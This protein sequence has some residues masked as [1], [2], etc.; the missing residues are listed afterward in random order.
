MTGRDGLLRRL[1]A[2]NPLPSGTL[3][4]G[5]GLLV[6][7]ITSYA[8]LAICSHALGPQRYAPISV[9]WALVYFASP[10]FF[11]PLEQE[12]G[13]ALSAR[14]V[15]GAGG[16]PVVR[17]AATAGFVLALVL[18]V[19]AAAAQQPLVD[20]LF[21]G[22]RVLVAGFA[23]AVLAYAAYY[24]VRGVLAGTGHFG[25]YGLLL[26]A[27]GLVRVLASAA[28][29]AAGVRVAGVYGLTIA[30]GAVAGWVAAGRAARDGMQ[31]GPHA[32]WSEITTNIGF[33]LAG[34]AAMQLLTNIGPLAVKVLS[35]SADQAA[36]GVFFNG[37][38]IARIPLFLFQAVQAS[39]LPALSAQ[40]AAGRWQEFRHGLARLLY[41]VA[42]L[43]ALS[44]A[45]NGLLGPFVV[46]HVFGA[47]FNLSHL[48]MALLAAAS[49][50][51]M[52]G[53]ALGQALIALAG[54]RYNAFGW[55]AGLL[56]F[57]VAVALLRGGVV[58]RVEMALVV[59]S[60]ANVAA[61]AAMLVRVLPRAMLS[62]PT[63]PS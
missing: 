21:D 41:G 12:V 58:L 44:V 45:G 5:G 24:L 37:L 57:L 8:F 53:I 11:L 20:H 39:L 1:A 60:A 50:G 15:H 40:A 35:D 29:A 62:R 61:M 43:I 16:L 63:A 52:A 54:H 9:L 6:S 32:A 47:G 28:L 18:A 14:R 17:R 19:A 22:D 4:V 48:D 23:L 7:G 51:L 31:P 49:G 2:A 38:I 46:S 55:I 33:L 3:S 27:E 10:G 34:S 42:A 56:G 59:G 36:A 26:A 30:L 13:R 25:G